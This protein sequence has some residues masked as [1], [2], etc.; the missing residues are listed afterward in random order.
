M[1]VSSKLTVLQSG[2]NAT[3]TCRGYLVKKGR[4]VSPPSNGQVLPAFLQLYIVQ[5][6]EL[7]STSNI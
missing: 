2:V 1:A 3:G 4:T 5:C 6:V 7:R